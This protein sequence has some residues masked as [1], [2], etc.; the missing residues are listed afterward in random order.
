[1]TPTTTTATLLELRD[2]I[3]DADARFRFDE[4]M[5]AAGLDVE[6]PVAVLRNQAARSALVWL[7]CQ[8]THPVDGFVQLLGIVRL[9]DKIRTLTDAAVEATAELSQCFPEDGAA[10]ALCEHGRPVDFCAYHDLE[11]DDPT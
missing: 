2:S 11:E 6:D 10:G 7:A 9:S 1:M 5:V 8:E 3:R 4:L